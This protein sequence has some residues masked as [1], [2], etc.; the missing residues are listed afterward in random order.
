M[1]NHKKISTDL[2]KIF[3]NEFDHGAFP[4]LQAKWIWHPNS[5]GLEHKVLLFKKNFSL[6][7]RKKFIIHVSADQRFELFINGKLI[8]RGPERGDRFNWFVHSY[9][10]TLPKGKHTIVS[11]CWWIGDMAPFAQ[12]TMRG[13]FILCAE[14]DMHPLLSTGVSEWKVAELDAYKFRRSHVI[15]GSGTQAETIINGEKIPSDYRTGKGIKFISASNNF[16]NADSVL[17]GYIENWWKLSP[18]TLPEMLNKPVKKIKVVY[19]EVV[20]ENFIDNA[21]LRENKNNKTLRAQWQNLINKNIPLAIPPNSKIKILLDLNNY[22]CAYPSML[23]NKGKKS[24]IKIFWAESLFENLEKFTK[25]NRNEIYG[26]IF[27]G[28]GDFFLPNGKKTLFDTLWWRAGRYV[29]LSVSTANEKLIIEKFSFSETH[30]PYKKNAKLSLSDKSLTSFFRVAWRTMEMCSHET[31]MDCPY[32]E[33]LMYIGDTRLEVLVNY[34]LTSDTR[35]AEKAL[36]CFDASR[37]PFGLTQSRYPCRY[38]NLIPTFSLWLICMTH[39]YFM[40]RDNP[41]VIRDMLPGTDAI[42]AHFQKFVNKNNL[43]DYKSPWWNFVDWVPSWF[44]GIPSGTKNKISGI[45]NLQ[46]ILSLK[47]ASEMHK[48]Y[49]EKFLANE[50]SA[51]ANKISSAF[52]KKFWSDKKGLFAHDVNK[53]NFCEH[54]QCLAVLAGVPSKNQ[55]KKIAENIFDDDVSKTTIYF[56]H[57]LFETLPLI[58]RMDK[59]IEKID[60]WRQLDNF[61]FFTLPEAPNPSR[62][63]CHAWGAHP[64]FH[65]YTKI[66]GVNPAAPGFKKVI[67]KPFL[68][69]LNEISG[70][71]PHPK[72]EIAVSIKKD[73]FAEIF[74]PPEISGVFIWNNVSHP[75]KPGKQKIYF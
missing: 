49:G 19:A 51:R 62:S 58:G 39:D 26:K 35:L 28:K 56:S 47:A 32:Y 43:L 8:G 9:E 5:N 24:K 59:F 52:N 17:E 64:I 53:N 30:Y 22:Y 13:A 67:I 7:K 45:L 38:I 18:S 29:E 41:D 63:D 48:I 25:G 6:Q 27:H 10:I 57:Y 37:K 16:T 36:K 60:F 2:N 20:K 74:L 3:S 21:P 1:I 61:G 11:R 15:G 50:Y 14:N 75:L 46:Y 40:W 68:L 65:F 73:N 33:Q 42:I 23:V 72:G 31:F 69:G 66:L 55:I 34:I 54:T 70:K 4:K 44:K 71:I 12:M